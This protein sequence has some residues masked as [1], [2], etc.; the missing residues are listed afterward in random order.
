MSETL[1]PLIA[2]LEKAKFTGELAVRFYRGEPKDARLT[3]A[4]ATAE[5]SQPL[6]LVERENIP[7]PT[8]Q[9]VGCKHAEGN[10]L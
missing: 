5:F 10:Y 1:Q 2:K 8:C 7:V 6:P 4:L 3:H 9:E